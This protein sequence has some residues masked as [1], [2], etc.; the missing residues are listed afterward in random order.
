MRVVQHSSALGAAVANPDIDPGL[1]FEETGEIFSAHAQQQVAPDV[2]LADKRCRGGR[3]NLGF[4]RCIGGQ[5]IAPLGSDAATQ[6]SRYKIDHPIDDPHSTFPAA[7]TVPCHLYS[8]SRSA[9]EY[10]LRFDS[11]SAAADRGPAGSGGAERR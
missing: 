1:P 3:R 9:K 5:R 4:G 6:S 10:T 8:T 11:R 2:A 7:Q